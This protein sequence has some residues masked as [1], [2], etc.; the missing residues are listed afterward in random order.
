MCS[1]PTLSHFDAIA[2][3]ALGSA[4]GAPEGVL[5]QM[6]TLLIDTLVFRI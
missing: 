3:F 5:L 2:R 4:I 6:S 1:Q